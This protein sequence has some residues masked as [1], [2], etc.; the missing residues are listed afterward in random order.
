[1]TSMK[2]KMFCSRSGELQSIAVGFITKLKPKMFVVV[3]PFTN[4]MCLLRSHFARILVTYLCHL[5]PFCLFFPPP[6]PF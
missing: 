3:F 1:M 5:L 4:K 2:L 6:F